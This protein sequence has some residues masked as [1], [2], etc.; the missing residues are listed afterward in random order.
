MKRLLFFPL[1]LFSIIACGNRE[2]N[3][4]NPHKEE[5]KETIEEEVGLFDIS[6]V[7]TNFD[8]IVV[9]DSNHYLLIKEREDGMPEM[10]I[11]INESDTIGVIYDERGLP[12]IVSDTKTYIILGGYQ[13]HG[14]NVIAISEDEETCVE[15]LPIE[16]DVYSYINTLSSTK[17]D[18]NDEQGKNERQTIV[19][20]LLRT[21][22]DWLFKKEL[23]VKP[24]QYATLMLELFTYEL[25]P[26]KTW[27][28]VTNYLFTYGGHLYTILQT[29]STGTGSGAFV[30]AYIDVFVMRLG[31]PLYKA[32][33]GDYLIPSCFHEKI[34]YYYQHIDSLVC[35]DLIH[36]FSFLGDDFDNRIIVSGNFEVTAS[37]LYVVPDYPEDWL[38]PSLIDRDGNIYLHVSVN[39]NAARGSRPRSHLLTIRWVDPLQ[40]D[41]YAYFYVVQSSMPYADP[42]EI[43]FTEENNSF[44][45]FV[46]TDKSDWYIVDKPDWCIIKEN[47]TYF[48]FDIEK[49][50]TISDVAPGEIK[51]VS[52]TDFGDLFFYVKV[53]PYEEEPI[54]DCTLVC[55][56]QEL[57]FYSRGMYDYETDLYPC[58][59]VKL[60]TEGLFSSFRVIDKPEWC[61]TL[62]TKEDPLYLQEQD[63]LTVFVEE[64][65]TPRSG[66][67]TI[68]GILGTG[69][70]TAALD[71]KQY[72]YTYG[73]FDFIYDSMPYNSSFKQYVNGELV[74][75]SNNTL[76]FRPYFWLIREPD[77]KDYFG[78]INLF[79]NLLGGGQFYLDEPWPLDSDGEWVNY[80]IQQTPSEVSISGTVQ[81][82]NYEEYYHYPDYWDPTE[83][84]EWR[85]SLRSTTVNISFTK[86]N[87]H[88]PLLYF[89]LSDHSEHSKYSSKTDCLDTT[90][91]DR[92][93]KISGAICS[94]WGPLDSDYPD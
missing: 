12:A 71:I 15:Y 83:Y 19:Y 33:E 90:T 51:L 75:S 66:V 87:S 22:F 69:T 77:G 63:I 78:C 62:I 53:Y 67:I 48:F 2:D 28:K 31:I 32:W 93:G 27:Q 79:S 76:S 24:E 16:A 3:P 46:F 7:A 61:S 17:A 92:N 58:Y 40:I 82:E 59:T 41:S 70:V 11:L 60:L 14:F 42:E 74:S 68:E 50:N 23:I 1:L 81:S 35:Q 8:K 6:S 39:N 57:H 72:D 45:V 36:S 52:E 84:Y 91:E 25:S 56:P 13:Q 9:K 86:L 65:S 47:K 80:S 73:S 26:N 10:S 5:N 43:T 55:E 34:Q 21:S 38:H 49:D 85:K 89:E 44:R 94:G 54:S 88:S 29:E 18:G 64:T 30:M 37:D 20:Q 4:E